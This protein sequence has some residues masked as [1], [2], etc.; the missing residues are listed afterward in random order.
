MNTTKTA[1][2]TL[3]RYLK[4]KH[5]LALIC[6]SPDHP[7]TDITDHK[8]SDISFSSGEVEDIVVFLFF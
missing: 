7:Q 2:I 6:L 8:K 4:L 1:C 3:L 5:L